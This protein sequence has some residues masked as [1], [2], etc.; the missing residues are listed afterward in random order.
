MLTLD[1]HP[2]RDVKLL[3]G[4]GKLIIQKCSFFVV[5]EMV[6]LRRTFSYPI[7]YTGCKNLIPR[8][9]FLHTTKKAEN[10]ISKSCVPIFHDELNSLNLQ[11]WGFPLPLLVPPHC[12]GR[13]L[14]SLL[15]LCSKYKRLAYTVTQ[16]SGMKSF[17]LLIVCILS[18]PRHMKLPC[19]TAIMNLLLVYLIAKEYRGLLSWISGSG[20]VKCSSEGTPLTPTHNPDLSQ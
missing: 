9:C 1:L 11:P 19:G 10:C 5:S 8:H 17:L 16:F 12:S 20:H 2:Q 13:P 15:F 3:G 6:R 18:S 14:P 4:K 7:C